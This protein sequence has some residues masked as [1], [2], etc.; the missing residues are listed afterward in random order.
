M[1]YSARIEADYRRFVKEHGAIM[2]LEDFTRLA[3]AFSI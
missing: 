3:S 1:C 2:S